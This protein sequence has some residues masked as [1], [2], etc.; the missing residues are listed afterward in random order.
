MYPIAQQIAILSSPAETPKVVPI[1]EAHVANITAIGFR[2]TKNPELTAWSA[3]LPPLL[4]SS[5]N[6]GMTMGVAEA[7]LRASHIK[8][9][10]PLWPSKT[11]WNVVLLG[12]FSLM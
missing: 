4:P 6:H 1:P 5:L 9:L 12:G 11:F 3:L 2:D 10:R 7:A 8:R